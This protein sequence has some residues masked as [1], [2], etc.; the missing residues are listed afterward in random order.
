MD[1]EVTFDEYLI[2]AHAGR[3][4]PE[5]IWDFLHRESD[6]ARG[7]PYEVML[8]TLAHSLN[9]GAY[10]SDG[11]QVGFARIVTDYGQFAY[12]CD[13][14]I[15]APYRGQGLGKALVKA[16]LAHPALRNL[17]RYALDASD[18]ARSLYAELGFA[19]S[20]GGGHME[21][22]HRAAELWSSTPAARGNGERPS[23]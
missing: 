16:A 20:E 14:F 8:R 13:V 9:F 4:Q 1:Y 10:T 6:W 21:I 11:R 18:D 2:S 7:I 5:V 22:R 19:P 15:L 17:R 3:L 23:P 12:L